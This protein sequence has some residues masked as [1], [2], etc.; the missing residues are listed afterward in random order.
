M[1]SPHQVNNEMNDYATAVI[2]DVIKDRFQQAEE[3]T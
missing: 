2:Y 1:N 3:L